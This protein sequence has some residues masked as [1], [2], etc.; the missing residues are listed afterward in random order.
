MNAL[1]N[2]QIGLDLAT[3]ATIVAA[4]FSWYLS[5]RREHRLQEQQRRAD[6]LERK[7]LGI[8]EA[9]RSAAV[10]NIN[11]AI[12][13]M[14]LRFSEIVQ[15]S[16]AI[17]N[18]IDRASGQDGGKQLE[19]AIRSGRVDPRAIREKLAE[20]AELLVTY[21]ERGSSVR[22]IV[23]PSL[24]AIGTEGEA[25]TLLNK[26]CD[27][28]LTVSNRV[29]SGWT[30]LL[31]EIFMLIE[32]ISTY[33]KAEDWS[34]EVYDGIRDKLKGVA[35]SILYDPN[36]SSWTSSFVPDN[37]KAHFMRII[38]APSGHSF[39]EE[40]MQVLGAT[41][42]NL[43]AFCRDD[44]ERLLSQILGRVSHDLMVCRTECKEF[45]VCLCSISSK[46]QQKNSHLAVSTIYSELASDKYFDVQG[47]VR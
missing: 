47:L 1:E 34:A 11:R 45:L 21:Y 38:E 30:A 44:P 10:D 7:E 40:E 14:G 19:E 3:S 46:L 36:Y 32:Q 26:S 13:D 42:F 15:T 33:P 29:R 9:T 43:L 2:I 23:L 8:T 22:Y 20:V 5:Q 6:E 27:D 28:I 24:H 17:E 18:V 41:L 4:G 37:G 31:S 39:S 35:F 25:V 16:T 12:S